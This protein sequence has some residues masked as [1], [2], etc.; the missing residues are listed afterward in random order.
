MINDQEGD[1]VV[2]DDEFWNL[3]DLGSI[4]AK[5]KRIFGFTVKSG[6]KFKKPS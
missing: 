4:E 5:N 6:Q 2:D 3:L 1:Y